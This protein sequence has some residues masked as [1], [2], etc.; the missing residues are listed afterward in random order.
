MMLNGS[1][2]Q[3]FSDKIRH[4]P[5]KTNIFRPKIRCSDKKT[6]FFRL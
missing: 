6:G 2:K 1:Y 4:F 3:T 5:T